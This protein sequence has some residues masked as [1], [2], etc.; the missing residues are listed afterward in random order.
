MA[1]SP[2]VLRGISHGAVL[3]GYSL[4]WS[5]VPRRRVPI[6]SEAH[7]SVLREQCG[8]CWVGLRGSHFTRF[9]AC[10]APTPVPTNVGDTNLPTR[11][12]TTFAPTRAPTPFAP[13]RGPNFA[14]PTGKGDAIDTSPLPLSTLVA[15][16]PCAAAVCR[17][18]RWACH[19]VLGMCTGRF[20]SD[21]YSRVLKGMAV[22]SH[23]YSRVLQSAGG[24]QAAAVYWWVLPGTPGTAR[25]T[26]VRGCCGTGR[27]VARAVLSCAGAYVSGAAGS[28]ECPAGSE[29]I[30]TEAECRTAAAAAGMTI[31]SEFVET[32]SAYPRG[33]YYYYN[34][35]HS[36]NDPYFNADAV[37]AGNNDAQL[38]CAALTNGGT[39]LS[40]SL[41]PTFTT[42]TA[43]SFLRGAP[44]A[45]SMPPNGLGNRGYPC[46]GRASCPV[47]L[48][49][50]PSLP[51][52]EPCGT[53]SPISGVACAPRVLSVPVTRS[54][55]GTV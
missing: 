48:R 39:A 25:I 34:S 36:S 20:T 24:R 33:C 29:R 31:G 28:N 15:L 3:N 35:Y 37:G 14:D 51:S 21:G 44:H 52:A 55:R 41:A 2:T 5:I 32:A 13:T 45:H 22:S 8:C 54:V 27:G 1:H 46:A 38:L 53:L 17:C 23:R 40:T 42:S 18:E 50:L 16:P 4:L 10:A 12:P 26:G 43:P 47:K 6:S 9:Y 19:A 7:S 30:E 11:A 49:R